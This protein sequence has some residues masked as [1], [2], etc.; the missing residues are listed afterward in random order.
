MRPSR[1]G[2]VLVWIVLLPMLSSGCLALNQYHPAEVLVRDAETK[3][4]IPAAQVRI[5]YP[6]SR[7]SFAPHE[8]TGTTDGEGIAHLEIASS[9]DSCI[10]LSAAT[11]GYMSKPKDISAESYRQIEPPFWFRWAK[12]A[13]A[14]FIV[15]M[16][17]EPRFCIELVVPTGFRG[18]VKAEVQY[19]DE[20]LSPIGQRCFTYTVQ[21][22]GAVQ[23]VAPG[24]LRRFPPVYRARY[25]DGTPLS[26]DMDALKIGF[27]WL[28]RDGDTEYFLVGTL[29]DYENF[30]R[31]LAGSHSGPEKRSSDSGKSRGRGGRRNRADPSA[32]Q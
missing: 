18:L 7:Y 9:D 23:I 8:S 19:Q 31:D 4:P 6:I 15:E 30:S 10:L 21:P 32:G 17:A 1:L 11:A 20:S 24:V 22:T 13:L 29:T 25:A 12:P 27:R 5:S 2:P 3:K 16:Y 14:H 26:E 28:K